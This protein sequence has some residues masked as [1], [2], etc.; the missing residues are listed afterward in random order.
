MN[1]LILRQAM[2]LTVLRHKSAT[3]WPMKM[4]TIKANQET[5]R[6]RHAG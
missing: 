3:E 1:P 2:I 6:A 4:V 5:T